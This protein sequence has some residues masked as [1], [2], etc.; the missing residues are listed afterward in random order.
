MSDRAST[1]QRLL[2]AWLKVSAASRFDDATWDPRP[3]QERKLLEIVQRNAQTEFGKAHGFSSI[4]GIA[5][6][7]KAVPPQ[8]YESLEPFIERVLRGEKNV[9]TA[10]DP[11]MFATTSGTTGSA[12]YIPVTPSYLHEYSHGVHVHT[13]RMFTDFPDLLNGKM[14]VPSSNDVEGETE[15]GL[16]YGAISG[17]LTR[18]QPSAIKRFYALPY[19]LCKVKNVES[20]YYLTLRHA[21]A[22]DVRVIIMPNPSSLMLLAEKMGTLGDQ[23]VE[24]IEKGTVNPDFLAGAPA[25]LKRP[26]PANPARAR[27][28][29]SLISATGKLVPREAWPHLRL[30]SC[31][32]GG[33]MPLYLRRLPDAYGDTPVRDL[34]Y[35]ASEGRGATPLVNSGAA[36]VMN[37]TSHFF[38]FLPEEQRDDANPEFLTAD[39]LVS[40]R[41]YY[42]YFTTSAGLYRYDI[43]DVVRVVD[44]YRNTP[45][46]Q[47]VRKGQGMTNITGEKL[48]E[49]QVTGA[50]VD[51][52]DAGSYEIEHFTACVEWAETPHYALYAELGEGMTE[53]R[54]RAFVRAFDRTLMSKNIEYEAKRESQRL[55]APILKRVAPGTYQALRQA[56]VAAGA[57]EAQV[58]IP[59]L[60]T[61]M[62]FGQKLE[63][64]G[65]YPL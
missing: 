3:A 17:Y 33:T 38:E 40:N 1:V 49:A 18:T 47:F 41:E 63:V 15:A 30:L 34:G 65:E 26:L 59:Q 42:I 56:R 27:E 39:Q 19:E 37:V 6:F 61:S 9:L 23:L 2:R 36:G 16:T 20:K 54:C 35:M 62:E 51:T 7:Q 57:P 43:N 24:D 28:L 32:K 22:A 64:T 4:A 10:D 31:W 48:T 55:G 44:F 21:L 29:R 52:V 50:L 14:L 45:V 5:D 46:I 11:L 12:K 60:S 8:T 58:K 13:Y 25:A 53:E